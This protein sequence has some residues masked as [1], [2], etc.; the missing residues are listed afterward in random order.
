MDRR[1]F[2][3]LAVAAAGAALAASPWRRAVAALARGGPSP[4][5][6]LLPPD[7]LGIQLPAGFRSRLIATARERV[8]GTDYVWPIFPDGAATFRAGDGGWI[9]VANSEWVAPDGGGVS[10]IRFSRSGAIADAYS[11]C[12]GTRT[13]CAGGATPW[14][15]WLTC[16]EY[17]AGNVW[18]CDPRGGVPAV[19]RP[20]LGTFQHEAVAVDARHHRLYLTEDVPDGRLYRFTPAAWPSLEAGAL[21][22]AEVSPEG[23]VAWH[24]VPDPTG[25]STP[26]RHQVEASTAFRGGEGIAVSRGHVYFTTKGDDRVWDYDPARSR[27]SVLYENASDPS[28]QLSGVDNVTS[29]RSGDLFVAE[30]GGNME[31]VLI[32][33]DGKVSPL[34]R[35]VGQDGSELAGPAFSPS[36]RRLYVN[37]Q[38]GGGAGLTYEITGPFR[39]TAR[40]ARTLPGLRVAG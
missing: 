10:A 1:T 13:N 27:L 37:S 20:A 11:I 29:S 24:A 22:V 39:A 36:G 3:R 6:S 30:D 16:E 28:H 31:L 26:T 34:L 40:T 7:D 23:V 19:R 33:P 8:A 4:Y 5:G 32:A 14:G 35:V 9:Y 12:S 18:E 15:T 17:P 21:E 38:R 2:G 25:S